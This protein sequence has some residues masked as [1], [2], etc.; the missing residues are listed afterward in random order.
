MKGVSRAMTATALSLTLLCALGLAVTR[1]TW[2]SDAAL[3]SHFLRH[4]ADFE[5]LLSMAQEDAH[6]VRVAPDF[7]WLDDDFA[8]PRKNVGI[9]AE[10]WDEYRKLFRQVDVASGL[11]KDLD[12]PRIF[13]PVIS[14]GLVPSGYEK[15]LVYS[16]T[17]L[18]PVLRSLDEKPPDQF[19][20]GSHVL[21]YR[22]VGD[23]WYIYF[24]QW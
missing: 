12:P 10:R 23:H 3:K 19:W 4:R 5:K 18:S 11:R 2:R 6:V 20:E 9:S 7:T 1:S 21:V 15:G 17:P 16:P 14:E 22:P 13:F 8:W 24:K